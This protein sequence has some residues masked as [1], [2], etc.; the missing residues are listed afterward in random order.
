MPTYIVKRD[1]LPWK[2]PRVQCRSQVTLSQAEG[3]RLVANGWGVEVAAKYDEG[4]SLPSALTNQQNDTATPE[5]VEPATS[6]GGTLAA[7][8]EKAKELGLPTYGTKAQLAERIAKHEAGQAGTPDTDPDADD[9][10]ADD[11]PGE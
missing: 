8:Q 11:D 3:D 5:S 1:Y 6:T 9:D 4:G 2:G 10:D 7:L